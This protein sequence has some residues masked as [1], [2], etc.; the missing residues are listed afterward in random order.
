MRSL[1]VSL[2]IACILACPYECAVKSLAAQSSPRAEN[3]CCKAC[4]ARK[5]PSS[6]ENSNRGKQPTSDE[7]GVSCLCEGVVFEGTAQRLMDD[8]ILSSGNVAQVGECLR[9]AISCLDRFF[10]ASESPPAS[11]GGVF[12]RILNQSFLL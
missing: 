8:A 4:R 5:D 3:D 12:V 7:D 2:L 10:N 11:A 6:H 9:P 1:L